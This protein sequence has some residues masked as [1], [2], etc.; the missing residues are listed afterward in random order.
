MT[1]FEKYHDFMKKANKKMKTKEDVIQF[2]KEL[3]KNEE[4][5]AY[6]KYFIEQIMYSVTQMMGDTIVWYQT[7]PCVKLYDDDGVTDSDYQRVLCDLHKDR[8]FGE[9]SVKNGIKHGEILFV[10]QKK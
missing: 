2:Q 7:M 1:L 4:L 3:K 10:A 8:S 6:R 5:M 9:D